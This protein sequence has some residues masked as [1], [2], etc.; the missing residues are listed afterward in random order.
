MRQ[1]AKL[2]G[3]SHMTVYRA[4]RGDADVLA[5]T[6]DKI[7]G[8]AQQLGYLPPVPHAHSATG[9]TLLGYIIHQHF[10]IIGM[11]GLRGA[12][13]EAQRYCSGLTVMQ[14]PQHPQ[15]LEEAIICQCERGIS[16][17]I[18]AHAYPHLLP[19][20][21]L[22]ALRSRGIHVVQLIRRLFRERLDSVCGHGEVTAR[23][24]AEHL[25]QRG[26][27]RVLGHATPIVT[28]E[29]RARGIDYTDLAPH[30]RTREYNE[31]AQP[32]FDI[33]CHLHPRP[34]AL[35]I[36]G[37]DRAYRLSI[38]ARERGISIPKDLSI[39]AVGDLYGSYWYPEMTTID[40]QPQEMGRA[41]V[42]LLFTRIAAGIPPHEITDF[43]DIIIPARI[44]EGTSTGP[45]PGDD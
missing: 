30:F 19:H 44:I 2:A 26:H 34:T 25:A 42:R 24:A 36:D 29:F 13:E 21:I 27:R 20:R 4:L 12:M 23:L 43:E 5:Q 6:R 40:I 3:V 7:T 35:L 37:N 41:A 38:M 8:I 45:V 22:V 28:A 18:L 39:L 31:I 14:V 16:G 17:L 33:F 10:G 11:D 32:F 15:W 1:I 9:N